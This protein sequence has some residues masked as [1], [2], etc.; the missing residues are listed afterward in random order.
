MA[1]NTVEHVN[2][3]MEGL[4]AEIRVNQILLQ[5]GFKLD[6]DKVDE[7]RDQVLKEI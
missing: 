2:E 7:I 3:L 5:Q 1:K 6:H 4:I